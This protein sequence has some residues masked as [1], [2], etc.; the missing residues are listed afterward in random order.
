MADETKRYR[1]EIEGIV[2]KAFEV[3]KRKKAPHVDD[4]II[5]FALDCMVSYQNEGVKNMTDIALTECND[6]E[7]LPESYR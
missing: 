4:T 5:Q 3:A 1:G 6:L 7:S 2:V